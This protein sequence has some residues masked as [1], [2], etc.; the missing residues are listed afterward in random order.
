MEAF[1]A[2]AEKFDCN[3]RM[4]DR[5]PHSLHWVCKVRHTY[6]EADE[7]FDGDLVREIYQC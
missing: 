1:P 4:N 5:D 2:L 3:L 7:L 6:D